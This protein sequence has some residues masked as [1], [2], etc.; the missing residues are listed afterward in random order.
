MEILVTGGN[1]LLGQ[2]LK[3]TLGVRG[4]CLGRDELDILDVH[5]G[6]LHRRLAALR[7]EGVR[8]VINCAAYTDVD[9]AERE[10]D[11]AEEVNAVAVR[12]LVIACGEAG[13]PLLHLSADHVFDGADPRG[14]AEDSNDFNPLNAYGYSKL[15]GERLLTMHGGPHWL[16]RTSGLFGA[17]G[18]NFVDNFLGR[19]RAGQ[20]LKVAAD[21]WASPTWVEHLAPALVRL[22]DTQAPYGIYHLAAAG[23]APWAAVAREILTA[24]GL[25][26]GVVVPVSSAELARPARRPTRP[27][28]RNTKGAGELPDWQEGVRAYLETKRAGENASPALANSTDRDTRSRLV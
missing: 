12:W 4:R 6:R 18:K 11:R 24:E 1:G 14:Y 3:R 16:V 13:L 10:R 21:Q 2:A 17:G 20:E 8:A 19:V 15:L 22:I 25:E 5:T 26:P 9:G 7:A 28:L 27:Y 23:H